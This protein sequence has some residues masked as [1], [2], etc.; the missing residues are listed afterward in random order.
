M[1]L[2]DLVRRPIVPADAPPALRE[3]AARKH[4]GSSWLVDLHVYGGLIVLAA[5]A[6]WVWPPAGIM[7]FGAGILA[8]GRWG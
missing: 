8:L 3:A 7:V 4:A 1:R 2:P 6:G 5:G